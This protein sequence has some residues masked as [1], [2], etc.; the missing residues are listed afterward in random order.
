MNTANSQS[1]ATP[2]NHNWA[3]MTES[4][5]A[6]L[7]GLDIETLHAAGRLQIAL[8]TLVE[9][10]EEA[11]PPASKVPANKMPKKTKGLGYLATF[12]DCAAC[13]LELILHRVAMARTGNSMKPAH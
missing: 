1:T 7:M 3:D 11:E 2:K 5:A 8:D 4:E 12:M 9:A 10:F 6:A 13:E